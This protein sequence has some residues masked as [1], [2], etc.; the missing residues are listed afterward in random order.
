MGT[1][2][3]G[4]LNRCSLSS[5]NTHHRFV[6]SPLPFRIKRHEECLTFTI[7]SGDTI[8][9]GTVRLR[10]LR[11]PGKC[12][13]TGITLEIDRC[14]LLLVFLSSSCVQQD[15]T[16]MFSKEEKQIRK[17]IHTKTIKLV[18]YTVPALLR[19]MI[20]IS[21]QVQVVIHPEQRFHPHHFPSLTRH[22]R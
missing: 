18:A 19:K 5:C 10:R 3:S 17:N 20:A 1:S 8:T 21:Q 4:R 14:S 15:K 13:M 2:S 12:V 9:F 7:R 11:L 22:Q 16:E 6:H